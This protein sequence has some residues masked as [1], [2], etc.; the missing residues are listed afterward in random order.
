MDKRQ[1]IKNTI[2]KSRQL[3]ELYNSP[4]YQV[5][6]RGYLESM[7]KV[8]WLDPSKYESRE[9]FME[10]YQYHRARAVVGAEIMHFLAS[11][12]ALLQNYIKALKHYDDTTTTN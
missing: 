6:L 12:E 11:Q 10:D 9:K 2:E 3:L 4:A 5:H 7:T 8:E 1:V